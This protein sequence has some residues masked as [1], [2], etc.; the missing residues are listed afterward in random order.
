MKQPDSA[1]KARFDDLF[2][3]LL[4][5]VAEEQD[6]RSS[7]ETLVKRV[8]V[9]DRLHTLRSELA[10]LRNR[11]P[12]ETTTRPHDHTITNHPA[13]PYS[14]TRITK[15]DIT[16]YLYPHMAAELHMYRT[17]EMHTAAERARLTANL[18]PKTHSYT[19]LVTD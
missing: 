13:T 2:S 6:I 15:K 8:E 17:T 12:T 5:T 11:L 4:S 14:N 1:T 18:A 16:M 9:R 7:G 10:A 3:R 19:L